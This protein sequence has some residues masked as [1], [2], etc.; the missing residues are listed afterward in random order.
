MSLKL[1]PAIPFLDLSRVRLP[2]VT[3]LRLL[4]R[5]RLSTRRSPLQRLSTDFIDPP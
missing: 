3:R 1:R 2:V 5:W 4:S